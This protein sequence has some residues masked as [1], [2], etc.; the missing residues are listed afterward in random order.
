MIL[1]SATTENGHVY[2][3]KL[4]PGGG[5]GGCDLLS[6]QGL[7]QDGKII[8][9]KAVFHGADALRWLLTELEMGL[10]KY[11]AWKAKQIPPAEGETRR[12]EIAP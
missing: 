4:E 8:P 5:K 9:M 12:I 1:H 7:G 11:D 6:I 3:F 10:K 2:M